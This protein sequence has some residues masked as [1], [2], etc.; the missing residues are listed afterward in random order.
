MGG[1]APLFLLVMIV[2]AWLCAWVMRDPRQPSRRFW[3]FEMRP[4][5]G[6]KAGTSPGGRGRRAVRGRPG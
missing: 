2:V 1:D 6:G 3:P 4:P 5:E